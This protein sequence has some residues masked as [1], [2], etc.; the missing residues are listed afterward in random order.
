MATLLRERA[1]PDTV[2]KMPFS[3]ALVSGKKTGVVGVDPDGLGRVV[4]LSGV[5][6]ASGPGTGAGVDGL[7]PR[8]RREGGRPGLPDLP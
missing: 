3:G 2:V 4:D 7:S 6:G 8:P 1:D 5:E